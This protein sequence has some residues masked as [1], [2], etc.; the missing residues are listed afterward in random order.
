MKY[1]D[2]NAKTID[3]W[4]EGGWEWSI[5][6]THEQFQAALEGDWEIFM[7]PTVPVPRTWLGELRGARVL[8]LA[9][10][11]GQQMPLLTA[12]G[13]ETT[14]LDYSPRMLDQDRFV[15]EREGIEMAIIRADMT[16]PLPFED[17]AFDL[18][19][20][21]VSNCY[22]EAIAPIFKECWRVL[23]PGGIL[24]SGLDIGTNYIVDPTERHIVE[25][26]P[27]N[28]L[29]NEDQRAKCQADGSGYQFSHTPGE[30]LQAQLDAGFRLTHV[31]DDTNGQGYLHEMGIPSFLLTRAV[32]DQAS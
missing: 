6:V 22:V 23:K 14:V 28:P 20:H 24:V 26:L 29:R 21:P 10:A 17:G 18:I 12:A 16:E 4:V 19:V 11:G 2:I 8:G 3:R 9:S 1:Q 27:F 25:R 30:Q 32:K 7:T 31:V 5:P 13:A 15:A